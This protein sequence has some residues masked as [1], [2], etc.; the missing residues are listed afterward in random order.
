MCLMVDLQRL[1]ISL[2]GV[3]LHGK[4]ANWLTR[5]QPD[6]DEMIVHTNTRDESLTA[7]HSKSSCHASTNQQLDLRRFWMLGT[8]VRRQP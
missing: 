1:C 7:S 2:W 8:A 5:I 3:N 4:V 6:F